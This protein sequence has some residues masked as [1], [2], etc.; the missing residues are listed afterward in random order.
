MLE[1]MYRQIADDLRCQIEAGELPPGAQLL[2]EIE[3]C[4]KYS[5]SRNTVRDAVKW[6]ISR[7]LVET[8]R[9]QG[10]FVV[11][12][13]DPFVTPLSPASADLEAAFGVEG[14]SYGSEVRAQL[15][16]PETTSPRIELQQAADSVAAELH[17]EE[18]TTVVSRHQQRFID[19]AL[20]SLQT[21]FYPMSLAERGAVRLL[22]AANIDEGAAHYLK[23]SGLR[24][25]GWRDKIKVRTPDETEVALFRLPDDG[26]VAV[27]ETRR[28]GF[29]ERGEPF[30]L[31]ISVYPADR[32]EFVVS[33]GDLPEQGPESG[34]EHNPAAAG[35]SS[36]SG[37]PAGH[38][39]A[40]PSHAG[41]AKGG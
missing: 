10:T 36:V 26:R 20:W 5:A 40:G 6:L 25:A 21:S 17:L 14:T 11:E 3:L 9:G 15:R 31:T 27:I 39:Y 1:P 7:G 4:E 35:S 30:V 22:Q 37:L 8:R 33:V 28:T 41:P 34:M 13:I 32:N 18:G 24:L 38:H 29:D 19:G 2:T 23:Q 16:K 12:K